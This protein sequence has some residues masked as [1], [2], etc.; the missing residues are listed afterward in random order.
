[1]D[2]NNLN[3]AFAGGQF[4]FVVSDGARP[5]H[6]EVYVDGAPLM[7]EDCDD[8]PCHEMVFIPSGTRGAE[9]WVVARDADGALAQ[10]T[11]RV[12]TPDPSAGGVLV[13]ATR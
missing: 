2:I 5:I 12:G 11:F 9:L 6:I 8:P 7:H 3:E 13:G 1:M 4:H 10:R